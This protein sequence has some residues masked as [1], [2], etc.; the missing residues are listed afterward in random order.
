MTWVAVKGTYMVM[1]RCMMSRQR[2]C[3]S[4]ALHDA[5][6]EPGR[7]RQTGQMTGDMDIDHCI[8]A[9]ADKPERSQADR[10]TAVEII[11]DKTC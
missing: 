8:A 4:S 9:S 5:S 1:Q 2:D 11:R 6:A 7:R 3:C 10:S